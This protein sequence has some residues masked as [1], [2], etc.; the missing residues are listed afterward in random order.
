MVTLSRK[1]QEENHRI[2]E[3]DVGQENRCS[4]S[5]SNGSHEI[6]ATNS[7]VH[8]APSLSS[9]HL[10][11]YSFYPIRLQHGNGIETEKWFSRP[12]ELWSQFTESVSWACPKFAIQF[13]F[14]GGR[15][16]AALLWGKAVLECVPVLSVLPLSGRVQMLRV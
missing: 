13:V 3:P 9:Q 4:N 14:R 8:R 15:Q 6:P 5:F 16:S 2:L 11:L 7:P 10:K 12:R 1:T